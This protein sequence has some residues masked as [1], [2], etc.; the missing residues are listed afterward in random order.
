[1]K[2]LQ[3]VENEENNKNN[4]KQQKLHGDEAAEAAELRSLKIQM[5][6]GM[7]DS[8]HLEKIIDDPLNE[9]LN[10]QN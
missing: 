10:T 6:L 7:Q 3:K 1:M 9:L 2:L 8:T 4:K 5:S